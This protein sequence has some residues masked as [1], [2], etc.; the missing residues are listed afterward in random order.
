M[1]TEQINADFDRA[2]QKAFLNDL[3][4]VIGPR[5]DDPLA[6]RRTAGL[7]RLMKYLRDLD[8]LGPATTPG[9]EPL[10]NSGPAVR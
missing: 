2:R 5:V 7:A 3:R 9:P 1:Y 10:Q 8:R 6:K 4:A